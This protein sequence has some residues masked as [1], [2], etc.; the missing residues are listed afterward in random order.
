MTHPACSGHQSAGPGKHTQRPRLHAAHSTRNTRICAPAAKN[1]KTPAPAHP[2][3][4]LRTGR[5]PVLLT[6]LDTSSNPACGRIGELACG[7]Y[8]TWFVPYLQNAYPG[9][10]TRSRA[11]DKEAALI[12]MFVS[13]RRQAPRSHH[14][15]KYR[16]L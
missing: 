3:E 11:G 5:G 16:G 8:G 15:L 9:P 4:Y 13:P 2:G 6:E 10:R 7:D 14:G 12:V 1:G